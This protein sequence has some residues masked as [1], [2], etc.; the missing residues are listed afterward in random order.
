MINVELGERHPVFR[1]RVCLGAPAFPGVTRGRRFCHLL[2]PQCQ[3]SFLLLCV[4][5]LS[6]PESQGTTCRKI[7]REFGKKEE[8]GETKGAWFSKR[9]ENIRRI[10]VFSR[11]SPAALSGSISVDVF[12]SLPSCLAGLSSFL[13]IFLGPGTRKGTEG[14][15]ED[16]G[17][18]GLSP[19]SPLPLCLSLSWGQL[20]P[21]PS[22]E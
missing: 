19:E 13:D 4:K 3:A 15:S 21:S 7:S 2:C 11:L 20:R 6:V 22:A 1:R 17:F 10:K 8:G 14:Q 16:L 5:L 9:Q 12:P 18:W